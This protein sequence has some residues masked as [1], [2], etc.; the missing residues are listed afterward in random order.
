[1]IEAKQVFSGVA[2]VWGLLDADADAGPE[3]PFEK[4]FAVGN[5]LNAAIKGGGTTV[6]SD[7]TIFCIH[8]HA[9]DIVAWLFSVL[10]RRQSGYAYNVGIDGGTSISNLIRHVC[11]VF[12]RHSRLNILHAAKPKVET[13]HNVSDVSRPQTEIGPSPSPCLEEPIA[14]TACWHC[15]GCPR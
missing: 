8:H 6:Y 3:L 2:I 4:N 11:R 15:K 12:A 7:R 13:V 14:I 5:S 10:L 9:A 1:M